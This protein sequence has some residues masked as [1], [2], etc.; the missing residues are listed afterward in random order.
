VEIGRV[1]VRDDVEPAAV[2]G[3]LLRLGAA[4]G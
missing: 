1:E 2:R 4:G 3:V